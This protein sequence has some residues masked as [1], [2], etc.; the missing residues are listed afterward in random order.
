MK[1]IYDIYEGLLQGQN[2]TLKDN[3]VAIKVLIK[4]WIDQ[5]YEYNTGTLNISKKPDIDGKYIVDISFKG[6]YKEV[7]LI[8]STLTNL[9]N[10]MF[11][12]GKLENGRFFIN[13]SW[14]AAN[15]CLQSLDGCFEEIG[16]DFYCFNCFALKS[17]EGGPKKLIVKSDKEANYYVNGCNS[18]KNLIG[19]PEEVDNFWCND[20]K[21]LESLEGSPKVVGTFSCKN[22][23]IK[24]LNGAPE[25]ITDRLQIIGCKKL[26]TTSGTTKYCNA[27]TMSY[28]TKLTKDDIIKNLGTNPKRISIFD[29][30]SIKDDMH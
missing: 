15:L 12:F 14:G 1:C 17:L 4:N 25:K 22:T 13:N 9:T 19:S 16:G 27:V 20:C 21:S 24:N 18:L 7:K 5:N 6:N 28:N 30:E 26:K 8:N 10:D 2:K 11:K 29:P 3:D 23:P